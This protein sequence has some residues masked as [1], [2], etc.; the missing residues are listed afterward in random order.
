MNC[1]RPGE[2][3]P[4][5]SLAGVIWDTP[6]PFNAPARCGLGSRSFAL[7]SG[8][9]LQIGDKVVRGI[10]VRPGRMA[11]TRSFTPDSRI[12]RGKAHIA[13]GAGMDLRDFEPF[14]ERQ[15]LGI[16]LRAAN[17]HDG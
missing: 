17:H 16:N 15:G 1:L 5:V 12:D 4:G 7:T 2:T 13:L 8:N 14:S 11:F 10:V 6:A 9:R 3:N